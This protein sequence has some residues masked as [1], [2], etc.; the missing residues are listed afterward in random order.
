VS[1]PRSDVLSEADRVLQ[2]ASAAGASVRLIGGVAVAQHRHVPEVPSLV[3]TYADID[4]V[5]HRGHDRVLRGVLESNGYTP[6]KAFN[7]LRGDRRLLYYDEPNGRQ[8]DVFVGQF[9]MCHALDLDDR[10]S[11]DPRTLSPADLL[12]TKLQIVQLNPKDTLDALALLHQH[13]VGEERDGDVMGV[14][15]L[16]RITS[17]DWGWFT[18]FTDNLA[19]V[20]AQGP[21]ILPPEALPAVSARIEAIGH[22]VTEA[23]KSLGWKARAKVGR[24]IPWY[25]L[26]EEVRHG[27]V[28]GG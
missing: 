26:P 9:L 24:R 3:R 2:L 22:A 23:K 11:Q 16:V 6:N 14:D 18:T 12:L 25:E 10:L 17:H 15:R 28:E 21:T 19:A 20:A 1:E 7:S 13:D 27:G 8:V 4:L 5:V